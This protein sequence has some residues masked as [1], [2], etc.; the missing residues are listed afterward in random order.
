MQLRMGH[1]LDRHREEVL[2]RPSV[3]LGPFSTPRAAP[4][5]LLTR[6]FGAC[7]LPKLLH[8]ASPTVTSSSYPETWQ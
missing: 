2:H 7:T 6:E 1:L 3:G 8:P 4:G 5:P